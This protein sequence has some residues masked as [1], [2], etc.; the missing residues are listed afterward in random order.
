MSLIKINP[1]QPEPEKLQ[2]AA[3]IIR[4]DGIIGYPTETVY[5]LGANALS[6]AAVEKI[7]ELKGREKN[8]PILIIAADLDQVK[9]LTASFPRHAEILANAFWPG[10]LTMVFDAASQLSPLLLGGGK[11]I[12]I[13][14]PANLICL[15]LIK[16]CG[17]PITSTSANL[18][19]K[20]NPITAQEVFRYFGSQLDAIIDGGAAASRTP[21]TVIAFENKTIKLLREGAIPFS[22]IQHVINKFEHER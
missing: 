1:Q 21:S 15:E 2:E 6:D 4:N 18:S 13:R 22:K 8:K 14:I 19:G 9:R 11:Q 16:I 20:E 17:V 12:G 7:F 10:A 3:D 5:G